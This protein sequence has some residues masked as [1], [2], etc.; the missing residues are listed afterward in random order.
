MRCPKC[1]S[2]NLTTKDSRERKTLRGWYR[3]KLCNDCGYIFRTIERCSYDTYTEIPTQRIAAKTERNLHNI[4]RIKE[5]AEKM[6]IKL[7]ED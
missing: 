1:N 3:K 4:N 5:M 7:A 2:F 6:E